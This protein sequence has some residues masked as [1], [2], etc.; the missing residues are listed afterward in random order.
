M[1]NQHSNVAMF[2]LITMVVIRLGLQS[3]TAASNP[4]FAD[5]AFAQVWQ[6]ADS[7]VANGEVQ[8]GYYW[9]PQPNS[10]GL[11][12]AYA[13]GKDGTRMVQYFDKSRMEIN[14]P[15]G[16]KSSPFYVT[17]GLLTRELISGKMQVGNNAFV[18]LAP[19]QIPLAS[20]LDD[21]TAPTYA[22]FSAV[23][24]NKENNRVGSAV[25]ATINRAGA[26]STAADYNSYNVTQG[27]F[28][29]ATQHNIPL[30]FWKFLNQTG[31][32]SQNGQRTNARL[33]DPWFYAT[34]YPISAA[35]WAKAR[36]AGQPNT[37]VLIQAFE[38]R[39]LTYVP[40]APASYKV[41]IGNIGQHYYQWRYSSP[42]AQL[43]TDS[44]PDCKGGNPKGT[45]ADGVAFLWNN[46]ASVRQ[47]V[48][49]PLNNNSDLLNPVIRQ[50]FAHGMMVSVQADPY[51]S[52]TIKYVYVLYDDGK[53][54]RFTDTFVDGSKDPALNPPASLIAPHLGF[55]KVWRED[56]SV[57]QRLGW[58]TSYER[59]MAAVEYNFF[60]RGLLFQSGPDLDHV[61]VLVGGNL[62]Y[63]GWTRQN[64]P[65]LAASCNAMIGGSFGKLWLSS[66]M[67]ATQLSCPNIGGSKAQV[68][69]QHFQ[70]G[71]LIYVAP[72]G[73]PGSRSLI[74][75]LF[76]D[77]TA[78]P[79][80][81]FSHDEQPVAATNPPAGLYT[82]GSSFRQEWAGF[83][84]LRDR[85]GWAT[86]P[87]R[88]IGEGD[89]QFFGKGLMLRDGGKIYYFYSL[90]L[91]GYTLP[92][93]WQVADE[94]R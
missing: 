5:P 16:D 47:Q 81:S 40:S 75:Y 30:V 34:G 26:T 87:E 49:C 71:H 19:A 93:Y 4:A 42:T 59:K 21:T 35:Y 76:K 53:V 89:Y 39:V 85:L 83:G 1:M 70:G 92:S 24:S 72:S 54:Q 63:T 17:N 2:V 22:S 33:N 45:Q 84:L 43:P 66:S 77:Y 64:V 20:D 41:Q 68:S 86:A 18:E 60:E 23:M 67:V 37:P 36:I 48:G 58:A 57:Q 79:Y 61:Y 52:K 32:I 28:E 73:V 94:P 44:D 31:L 51:D 55:G 13:E 15:D 50:S 56:A 8:R 25:N 38:R 88:Q 10:G 3:A 78:Y 27:Y 12:E 91:T 11:Q 14:N 46:T 82:P 62:Q 65:L 69:I 6:R 90:T 74:F 7:L 29:P 9:G 80:F